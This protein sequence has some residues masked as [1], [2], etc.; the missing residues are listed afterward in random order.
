MSLV[1]LGTPV[2]KAKGVTSCA[3]ITTFLDNWTNFFD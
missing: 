2:L 3:G 1:P